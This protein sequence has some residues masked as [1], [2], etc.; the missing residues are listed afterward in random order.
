MRVY[1]ASGTTLHYF[2]DND[3]ATHGN[4]NGYDFAS[5]AADFSIRV[6]RGDIFWGGCSRFQDRIKYTSI[7]VRE[8]CGRVNGKNI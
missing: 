3:E 1:Y 8:P 2:I 5:A 4:R 6:T 7:L